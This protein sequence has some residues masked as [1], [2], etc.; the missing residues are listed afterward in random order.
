MVVPPADEIDRFEAFARPLREAVTGL[1]AETERLAN[2]R[3]A[4]LPKL[5]SGQLRVQNVEE[6]VAA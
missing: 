2:A 3:D 4:I 1:H 6:A 5:V